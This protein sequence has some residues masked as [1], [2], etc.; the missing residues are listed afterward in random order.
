M[1][2]RHNLALRLCR[3]VALP[4]ALTFLVAAGFARPAEA[5]STS[6][7]ESARLL[8]QI[9]PRFKAIYERDEFAIRSFTAT[10]LPDGS[11]Y[12]KLETPAGA[13]AAEV[14][15]YDAASG[16]RTVVVPS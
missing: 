5:A 7:E 3:A 15:H 13:S 6:A 1:S 12:L 8:A 11:G 16:K 10:W 9:E 4:W 14:A 2:L